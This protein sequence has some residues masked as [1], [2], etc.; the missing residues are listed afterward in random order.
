MN[1]ARRVGPLVL[2]VALVLAVVAAAHP[3]L[4]FVDFVSFAGR[5][6]RL[7][8]GQELVSGLYPVGYPALLLAGKLLF[9]DVLVAGKVLGVLAGAGAVL[10]AARLVGPGPALAM[11]A[12][13]AFLAWG[14]VEGTD[15]PAAALALGALALAERRPTLAGLLAAAAC[16]TRYTGVAALPVVLWLSSR[17]GRTLAAFLAG[18][19]PHWALALALRMPLLPD[20]SQNM[21]IGAGAPTPLLSWATL[22]RWPA[23]LGRAAWDAWASW[24]GA[25]GLAGLVAGLI[26]RERAALALAG[27]ALLHLLGIGLAFSNPRLVLPATLAAGAA[28]GWLAPPHARGWLALPA[29]LLMLAQIPAARA[30]GEEERAL[31][32][33]ERTPVPGPTLSTSPDYHERRDGWLLGSASLRSLGGDPRQLSP[34]RLRELALARGFRSLAVDRARVR[35]AWPALA[36]LLQDPPPAG[37]ELVFASGPWRIYAFGMQV[38]KEHPSSGKPL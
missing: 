32:A 21:A 25:L 2:G 8:Q 3:G 37:Y 20:Q 18:T 34:D 38:P 14:S 13:P 35:S 27:Y 7:S 26:R 16:L 1:E 24:P 10:A 17:R 11:A 22:A 36:P 33:V 12:L 19:S 5:A 29:A 6:F 28:V 23:G 4:R 15:M 9:G 31:N 30:V